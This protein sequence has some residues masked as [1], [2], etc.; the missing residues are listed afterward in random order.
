GNFS[1][2]HY[3]GIYVEQRFIEFRYLIDMA[4]IPT[5]QE[6]QRNDLM[7]QADD[8]RVRAYLAAQVESFRKNLLVILNGK[9]L[10]LEIASQDILFTPGAGQLPTM[11]IGLVL[12]TSLEESQLTDV[13]DLS[14]SDRNYMGHAGWKE[15]VATS[16]AQMQ[17]LNSNAPAQDRSAQLTNYPTDL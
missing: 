7:A 16:S 1:I 9:P 13:N 2:N 14:L 12:R 8:P 15:V 5:F 17:I 4:E 11:R 3:S 10:T 6:L